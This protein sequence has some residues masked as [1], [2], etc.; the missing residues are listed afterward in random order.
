MSD[1]IQKV[2][3]TNQNR[4]VFSITGIEIIGIIGIGYALVRGLDGLASDIIN[5][6]NY[7]APLIVK[8]IP[9]ILYTLIEGVVSGLP[10]V[11]GLVTKG[12][13]TLLPAIVDGIRQIIPTIIDA[14]PQIFESLFEGARHILADVIDS[15]KS[16][17]VGPLMGPLEGILKFLGVI[18]DDSHLTEG[19]KEIADNADE[20]RTIKNNWTIGGKYAQKTD[21]ELRKIEIETVE[22]DYK[23]T[24]GKYVTFDNK[25]L[26]R[27]GWTKYHG[28]PESKQW[29]PNAKRTADKIDNIKPPNI[30]D[31]V[32]DGIGDISKGIGDWISGWW[33]FK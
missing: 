2:F 15:M 1:N 14:V 3:V 5:V 6:V 19:E 10:E 8:I 9:R 26:R 31:K 4:L 16:T 20:I 32:V 7:I 21:E 29:G 25:R 22:R 28:I 24:G 12:F 18:A 11:I 23:E 13:T 17:I 30:I 33:P 27:D